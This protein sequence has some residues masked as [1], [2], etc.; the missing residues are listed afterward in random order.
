MLEILQT[1]VKQRLAVTRKDTG[2]MIERV[3]N[4]EDRCLDS[5]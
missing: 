2:S 4:L 5:G 1:G 3:S